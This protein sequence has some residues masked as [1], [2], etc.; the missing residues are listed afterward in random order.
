MPEPAACAPPA[1]QTLFERG[2]DAFDDALGVRHPAHHGEARIVS[3]V[4]S[5]T[6]CLVDLG[7]AHQLVA[8]TTFC[9]HP[10][11]VVSSIQRVGGTKT[12][13]LERILALDPT[14]VVMNVDENRE[15]DAR[16]LSEHGVTVVTTH[17]LDP[18]DNLALYR[19]LGGIFNAREPAQRMAD[20]FRSAYARL[21]ALARGRPRRRALYL[22][23]RN[24]YMTVSD[25]TYI[26]RMLALAGLETIAPPSDDRYPQVD[27]SSPEL[28]VVD[29]ILLSSEP[30]PFKPRHADEI[31][32]TLGPNGPAVVDIDGEMT[33]WYGSRAIRGCEY[34]AGFVL[35][36]DEP[37]P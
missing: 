7:L 13:N 19:L 24:P 8:R 4:P 3:L 14:H 11:A 20:D 28:G 27:L 33:S 37:R 2:D 17:P 15:S 31:R 32:R 21:S 29:V 1:R 12:P 34:L 6:E 36:L 9:I 5:V 35:A 22:I 26:S 30:F 23:W 25:D 16:A 18:I 10:D